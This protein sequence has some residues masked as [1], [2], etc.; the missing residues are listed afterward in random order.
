MDKTWFD[1][2]PVKIFIDTSTFRNLGFNL[3][4]RC[5]QTIKLG[6]DNK[7]LQVVSTSILEGEFIKHCDEVLKEDKT[8]FKKQRV[9][10]SYLD[11][12]LLHL[13]EKINNISSKDV[14]GKFKELL[15]VKDVTCAVD[16][17]LVFEKYFNCTSPFDKANK[18]SEFPDAFNIEMLNTVVEPVVILSSDGD[19]SAWEKIG[20]KRK[21]YR[22]IND[23]MDQYISLREPEFTAKCKAAL[24]SSEHSISEQLISDYGGDIH[25]FNIACAHSEIENSDIAELT[26]D[27]FDIV[28]FDKEQ[29]FASLKA[30]FSGEADLD[31]NCAVYYYDSEDK[32]DVIWG[33]NNKKA[34][35]GLMIEATINITFDESG[36]FDHEIEDSNMRAETFHVQRDWTLFVEE[37]DDEYPTKEDLE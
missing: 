18:K 30:W 26:L 33:W 11:K 15:N 2:L 14:W 28:A 27:K 16:W 6:V 29:G 5:F 12:E 34:S 32:H 31:L 3:N 7:D 17:K 9:T 35:V 25:N 21:S 20:S 13:E 37:P 24:E 1:K 23:F 19:Y 8:A 36:D 22:N 10:R 4:H